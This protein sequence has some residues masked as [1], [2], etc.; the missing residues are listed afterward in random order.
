MFAP[1]VLRMSRRVLPYFKGERGH[2]LAS[3]LGADKMEEGNEKMFVR[4]ASCARR[5]R[6]LHKHNKKLIASK[7]ST[8]I[9][10]ENLN[11]PSQRHAHYK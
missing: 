2:F 5:W 1:V 3:G 7:T 9:Y 4:A 6:E 11:F 10:Q 8:P